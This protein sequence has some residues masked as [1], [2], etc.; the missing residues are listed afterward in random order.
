ME[1]EYRLVH[2][3]NRLRPRGTVESEN[4]ALGPVIE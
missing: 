4:T 1:N 3:I 2:G